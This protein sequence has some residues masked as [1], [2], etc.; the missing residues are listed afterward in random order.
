VRTGR[1]LAAMDAIEEAESEKT[2]RWDWT[3]NN[4][5]MRLV[6]CIAAGWVVNL[7]TGI[8]ALG[9]AI[10]VVLFVL[11]SVIIYVARRR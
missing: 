7:A 10:A 11:T 4:W 8:Y 2:N 1:T 9:T 5:G 3:W 6:Y